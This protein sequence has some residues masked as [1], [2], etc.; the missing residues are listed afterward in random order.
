[1]ELLYREALAQIASEVVDAPSLQV[2]KASL[3]WC[4][5]NH[6]MAGELELED[7]QNLFQFYSFCDSLSL[8]EAFFLS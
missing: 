5:G 1:M 2:L 7:L 6:L 8:L 4:E 3:I